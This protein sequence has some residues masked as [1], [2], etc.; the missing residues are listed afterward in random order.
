[1]DSIISC[2]ASSLLSIAKVGVQDT[3]K[4]VSL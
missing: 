3:V 2:L 1:M 4:L